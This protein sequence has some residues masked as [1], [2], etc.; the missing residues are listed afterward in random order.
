MRQLIIIF[1]LNFIFFD[2]FSQKI[3]ADLHTLAF[4]NLENLFDTINDVRKNDEA[5]PIMETSMNRSFVYWEKLENLSKVISEI[6]LYE[7]GYLPTLIGVCEIE[8]KF[9]VEDLINTGKLKNINYD[10]SHFDSPDRRGI[11]VGLIYNRDHFEIV[12]E[13]SV[14]LKLFDPVSGNQ[15]LTRD[16]H[17]VEGLLDGDKIYIIINHWPSRYGGAE[18]SKAFRNKAAELNKSIIDSIFQVDI[19][20]K[21]FTIGDFNDDPTDESI[22]IILNVDKD[23]NKIYKSEMYNPYEKMFIDGFGTL[24]YRGKWNMFDQIIISKNLLKDFN[25]SKFYFE[26]A[27]IHSKPYL[28]NQSGNYEGYPFRS[29]AGGNFIGGYSDHLPV[30]IILKLEQKLL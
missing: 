4:Y 19:K 30:Y 13:K 6:G 2:S 7:T 14:L 25:V 21:I 1:I 12:R 18:K 5:S 22:K 15:I 11:D 10:I 20:A 29:F 24:K 9:V 16:Q 8:N 27:Y 3:Q 26:G 23:Q 28:I 17:L